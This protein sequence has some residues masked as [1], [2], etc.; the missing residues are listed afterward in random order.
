MVY[1]WFSGSVVSLKMEIKTERMAVICFDL[2]KASKIT[3]L[4]RPSATHTFSHPVDPV[5]LGSGGIH[6]DG[7]I[8]S[9][10]EILSWSME[11]STD[12]FTGATSTAVYNVASMSY[13]NWHFCH[14][15]SP[16][17]SSSIPICRVLASCIHN[18]HNLIIRKEQNSN[19][20]VCKLSNFRHRKEKKKC[21]GQPNCSRMYYYFLFFIISSYQIGSQRGNEWDYLIWSND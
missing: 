3:P 21:L 9:E 20:V 13:D 16:N 18:D 8:H 19:S 2:S 14:H 4:R 7:I 5:L 11:P 6:S 15:K 12:K 17:K 1:L 10:S